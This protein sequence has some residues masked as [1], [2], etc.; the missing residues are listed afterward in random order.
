MTTETTLANMGLPAYN[1]SED[2][3]TPVFWIVG[4]PSKVRTSQAT[5][6]SGQNLAA[7]AV[8]AFTAA[9]KL[10]AHAPAATDG[11]EKAVGILVHAIDA[12]AA[13]VV[14]AYYT[15]GDF[16][17]SMCVWA[18]ATSTLLLRK[19]AFAGTGINVAAPL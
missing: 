11:T 4:D 12:S 7:R 2:A 10:T 13:D 15:A 18:A 5:V 19:A 3:H 16:N 8:V 9:G 17:H 1:G 14:G 6:A